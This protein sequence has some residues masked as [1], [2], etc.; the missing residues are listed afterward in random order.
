MADK[1]YPET[2]MH[3]DKK[4]VR[5]DLVKAPILGDEVIIRTYT[6]GVHV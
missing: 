4:Y 5:E 3:D 2:I 6:A 1:F